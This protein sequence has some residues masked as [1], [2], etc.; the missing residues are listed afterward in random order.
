MG[1]E[2]LDRE[3]M[4]AIIVYIG[5]GLF[6]YHLIGVNKLAKALRSEWLLSDS[7]PIFPQL[8]HILQLQLGNWW[9]WLEKIADYLDFLYD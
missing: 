1:L 6:E 7:H 5:E 2:N 8:P 9:R 4:F 3:H